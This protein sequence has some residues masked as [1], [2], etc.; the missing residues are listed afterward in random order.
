MGEA[1]G[2][3]LC[4]GSHEVSRRRSSYSR[5]IRSHSSSFHDGQCL[6]PQI[7]PSVIGSHRVPH[8]LIAITLVVYITLHR[9][10]R[11]VLRC[12]QRQV[13][14]TAYPEWERVYGEVNTV[15]S[16]PVRGLLRV[17]ARSP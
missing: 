9:F 1:E 6:L 3:I 16:R 15:E 7:F 11:V 17:R 4:P 5:A 10:N 8:P 14:A 2:R 12:T 13:S